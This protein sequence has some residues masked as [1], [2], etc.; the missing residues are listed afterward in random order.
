MSSELV[1]LRSVSAPGCST[2]AKELLFWQMIFFFF[3]GADNFS[4]GLKADAPLQKCDG[5]G[6]GL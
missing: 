3:F 2:A 5:G 6:S 4:V 1:V